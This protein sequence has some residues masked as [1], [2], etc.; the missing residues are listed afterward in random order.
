M[1]LVSS[2]GAAVGGKEARS[3]TLQ[4]RRSLEEDTSE[5]VVLMFCETA[6]PASR[7]DVNA[8]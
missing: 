4:E 3:R 8:T 5:Q 7:F 1:A 2:G 6:S